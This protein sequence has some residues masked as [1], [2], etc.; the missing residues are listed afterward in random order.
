MSNKKNICTYTIYIYLFIELKRLNDIFL[1]A[2]FKVLQLKL[3]DKH[4][5]YTI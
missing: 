4:S 3:F 5:N 1:N 2:H